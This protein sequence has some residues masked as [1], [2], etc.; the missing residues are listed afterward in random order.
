MGGGL[1]ASV[2]RVLCLTDL[3]MAALAWRMQMAEMR[4]AMVRLGDRAVLLD[5]DRFLAAP[6]P[7][8][9]VLDQFFGL[10]LAAERLADALAG[11]LLSRDAKTGGDG[12]GRDAR[13]ASAARIEAELGDR[14]DRVIAWSARASGL[15]PAADGLPNPLQW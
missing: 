9:G 13:D 2:Q 5:G 3:Q 1:S 15:D 12:A 14:L 8:L 4:N 11:G 6:A 10:D 7:A